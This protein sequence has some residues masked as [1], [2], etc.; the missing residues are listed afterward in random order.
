MTVKELNSL[1]GTRVL[2]VEE[3]VANWDDREEGVVI[4]SPT[5]LAIIEDGKL[6]DISKM[7]IKIADFG[8][9]TRVFTPTNYSKSYSRDGANGRAFKD[10]G[11][12]NY[13]GVEMGLQR[14]L[15]EFRSYGIK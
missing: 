4:Y 9:G 5:P 14:G 15:M 2:K 7:K 12:G 11:P 8:K 6:V 1:E 10:Y 13:S 3:I